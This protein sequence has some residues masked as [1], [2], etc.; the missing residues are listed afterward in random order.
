MKLI[1]FYYYFDFKFCYFQRGM[2][3]S[4]AMDKWSELTGSREGFYLSHQV[5]NGKQ[6]AILAIALEIPTSKKTEKVS[7]KEQMYQIYRYL[8]IIDI[9]ILIN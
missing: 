5:R 2:S 1:F 6:T 8:A 4:E 9:L 3:W 7:K